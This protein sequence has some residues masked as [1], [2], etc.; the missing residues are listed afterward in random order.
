[1]KDEVAV[2]R[3]VVFGQDLEFWRVDAVEEIPVAVVGRLE[4]VYPIV[5]ALIEQ[6]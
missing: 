2:G 4:A 5:G 1:M 6:G 3:R